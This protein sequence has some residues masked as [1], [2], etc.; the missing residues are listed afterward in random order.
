MKIDAPL[1]LL[2]MRAI[3]S[4]AENEETHVAKRGFL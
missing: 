4:P 2:G 3:M 1:P